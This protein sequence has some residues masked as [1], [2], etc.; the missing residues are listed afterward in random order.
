MLAPA[1]HT[2]SSHAGAQAKW[3]HLPC[4]LLVAPADD[5]WLPINSSQA[6]QLM[7]TSAPQQSKLCLQGHMVRLFWGWIRLTEGPMPELLLLGES[8]A[9][10]SL[11][12]EQAELLL[13][14]VQCPRRQQ[15]PRALPSPLAS[16][17]CPPILPLTGREEIISLD[18]W[19]FF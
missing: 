1:E 19:F 4:S 6:A 9:P 3:P 16:S 5:L 7:G 8:H 13:S 10:S 14:S 15:G 18:Q 2:P 17:T 12:R 11:I